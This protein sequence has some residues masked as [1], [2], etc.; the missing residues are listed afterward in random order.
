MSDPI[1]IFAGQYKIVMLDELVGPAS[2]TTGGFNITVNEVNNILF[3]GVINSKGNGWVFSVKDFSGNIVTIQAFGLPA[4]LA[5]GPLVEAT[6]GTDLSAQ[7]FSLFVV[8]V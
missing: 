1:I 7:K 8:G 4:T 3:A 2:Y 5:A 6:A